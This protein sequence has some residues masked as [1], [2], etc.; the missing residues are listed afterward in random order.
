MNEILTLLS[1]F[2]ICKTSLLIVVYNI[3]N[4]HPYSF[5]VRS[6]VSS[7]LGVRKAFTH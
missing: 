7:K 6:S 2:L 1:N 4:I 3:N 5:A